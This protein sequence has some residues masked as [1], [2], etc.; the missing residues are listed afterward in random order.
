MLVQ[1]PRLTPALIDW[2]LR[3]RGLPKHLG[4]V[5]RWMAADHPPTDD[6]DHHLHAVP[7][8]VV[9]LSGIVRVSDGRRRIDLAADEALV[10]QPGAWHLHED[11]RKG[12]LVYQQGFIR[13]R[14][15]FWFRTPDTWLVSSIPAEPSRTL[16]DRAAAAADE[17]VR[18]ACLVDLFTAIVGEEVEPLR[19]QHP[20]VAA[21]DAMLWRLLGE[22]GNADD[23]VRASGLGRAQAYRL[24]HD[25]HGAPP[26]TV[27]RDQR[28][29]LADYLLAAGL[30]VAE[31][32]AR[33]G[34]PSRQTFSRAYARWRGRAPGRRGRRPG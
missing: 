15:D 8:L 4:A 10:L 9:C 31:V 23:L 3:L 12:T 30:G 11:L 24:F 22:A 7:T 34:F 25:Q 2:W 32:A 6:A 5:H 33:C 14:S 16:L 19:P 13:G 26:A 18:H 29:L 21:M 17:E 20:A 27:L 1:G 28:L